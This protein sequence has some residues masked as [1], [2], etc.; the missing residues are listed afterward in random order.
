MK[1]SMLT[2]LILSIISLAANTFAVE[3]SADVILQS[4]TGKDT[5]KLYYKNGDIS[6]NESMGMISIMKRPLVYQIFSG[7]KK[8]YVSNL[9][10]LEKQN[11][12]AG[13][14]DFKS[15]IKKNNMKKVGKET[16]AGYKCTIYEGDI[17]SPN[18]QFSPHMKLWLPKELNYPIKTEILLPAPMGTITTTL[19]N[20]VIEK[21]P[22]SLFSIPA[23]Y[24]QAKTMQEAMGMPD[25]GSFMKNLGT[26]D[27]N[28]P[29][30]EQIPSPENMEKMM[31]QMQEMMKNMQQN[32]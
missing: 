5:G 4:P 30:G 11:A 28:S 18:A 1:I 27:T 22:K 24:V 23:G 2:V 32:Q 17:T 15:W 25:M 14:D 20:I 3:F 29:A 8:Y 31:E 26:E 7:T 19:A 12:M 21:Q 13:A 16:L 9:S 6:R 10:D